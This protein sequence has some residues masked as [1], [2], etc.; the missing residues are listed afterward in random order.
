MVTGNR[1]DGCQL[2]V[3]KLDNK[4]GYIMTLSK[5]DILKLIHGDAD[6]HYTNID[7]ALPL[8][9]VNKFKETIA[10][11]GMDFNDTLHVMNYNNERGKELEHLG[12]TLIT[13]GKLSE[14]VN[15]L[16]ELRYLNKQLNRK[17]T[18]LQQNN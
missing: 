12:S 14:I 16:D 11:F 18:E 2:P 4:K 8:Q 10:P 6:G 5:G 3:I 1:C 17:V 7:C 9:W 13:S 15:E